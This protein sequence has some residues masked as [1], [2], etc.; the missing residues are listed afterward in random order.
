MKHTILDW[1][2][3]HTN[4]DGKECANHY[5]HR[6]AL[7]GKSSEAHGESLRR[8][9]EGWELYAHEYKDRYGDQIG[10]DSYLGE[11]WETLGKRL[12][13]LLCGETGGFDCGSLDRNIR[14]ILTEN[15]CSGE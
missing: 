4:S 3:P 7:V 15:G 14:R 8:M 10:D 1:Q 2:G 5:H 9:L 11:E 12:L 6:H 13:R